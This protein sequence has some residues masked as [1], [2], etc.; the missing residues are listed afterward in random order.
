MAGRPDPKKPTT[1]KG[2]AGIW[3]CESGDRIEGLRRCTHPRR[4]LLTVS[5]RLERTN[6]AALLV[7]DF[8]YPRPDLS[9]FHRKYPR[10]LEEFVTYITAFPFPQV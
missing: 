8:L 5:G 3:H 7:S 9:V 1:P 6:A 10:L 2:A 4:P